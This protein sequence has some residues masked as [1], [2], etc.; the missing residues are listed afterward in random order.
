M[1]VIDK[2]VLTV[3]DYTISGHCNERKFI[4]KET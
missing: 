4:E 2:F 3:N 1:R